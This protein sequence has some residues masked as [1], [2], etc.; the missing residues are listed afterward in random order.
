MTPRVASTAN[1]DAASVQSTSTQARPESA[2][3]QTSSSNATKV[4]ER[5]KKKR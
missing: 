3:K 5:K 1:K 4:A 2:T